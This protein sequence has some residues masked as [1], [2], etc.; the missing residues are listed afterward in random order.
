MKIHGWINKYVETIKI[1]IH[2]ELVINFSIRKQ[3]S[4]MYNKMY[5]NIFEMQVILSKT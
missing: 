3:A 1:E 5:K 4:T 2:L